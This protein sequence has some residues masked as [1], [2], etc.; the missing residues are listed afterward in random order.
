MCRVYVLA[1]KLMDNATKG[2]IYKRLQHADKQFREVK[3]LPS[4]DAVQTIYYGTRKGDDMR[5]LLY[6][7]YNDCGSADSLHHLAPHQDPTA[8]IPQ[9]FLLDLAKKL[10]HTCVSQ[11]AF[12]QM[13]DDR[14]AIRKKL[15]DLV[16]E[17]KKLTTS[18]EE[19][20]SKLEAKTTA[21][22]AM[23]VDLDSSRKTLEAKVR[24]ID[25]RDRTIHRQN[26]S[27]NGNAA[28]IKSNANVVQNKQRII[29]EQSRALE[30]A[31]NQVKAYKLAFEELGTMTAKMTECLPRARGLFDD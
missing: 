3:C 14:D 7:V 24:Q 11:E 23:K 26:R 6:S 17:H 12:Y 25:A 13:R 27:I 15:L 4:I 16:D 9:E 28:T 10:F 29:E 8:A 18:N 19:I 21:Y 5:E 20:Q 1:Q 2:H 31:H 30:R 22:S